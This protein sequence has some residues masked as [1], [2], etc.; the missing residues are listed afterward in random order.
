MKTFLLPP[1]FSPDT[2]LTLTGEDFHYLVRVLR[3]R[4]GDTF[5]GTDRWGGR[6]RLRILETGENSLTAETIDE[7]GTGDKAAADTDAAAAAEG[8]A[9]FA[10][11]A[12]SAGFAG[13]GGSKVSHSAAGFAG[14]AGSV[15]F[16]HP[17]PEIH[18][19]QCLLKGKKMDCVIRKAVEAGVRRL[20]PVKS[21][22]TIP[23]YDDDKENKKRRR[24]E[25][26]VR[27]AVQQSG[28]A[29][30]T[31][32]SE[33]TELAQISNFF[34]KNDLALFFHHEPLDQ[35]SLHRYLSH[36]PKRVAIAIGP[37]GGFSSRETEILRRAGFYPV[38]LH[39]NVL[40]AE[41]A[42]VYALGAV[43]TI[44]T[45]R[46]FWKPTTAD[47]PRSEKNENES[48]SWVFR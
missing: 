16:S 30:V 17:L 47:P 20:I 27:E 32:L 12:G 13:P 6:Y 10:D 9:G 1:D 22:Y 40:R 33:P 38:H 19:F 34:G 35:S 42:A 25:A 37:E 46:A 3:L 21:D 14:P 31:E 18:L 28:S 39:T 44:L 43:Q 45:E 15:N 2:V 29:V 11:S 36:Y 7:H 41:T 24:W 8:S 5:S 48:S 26:I 23:V 4:T